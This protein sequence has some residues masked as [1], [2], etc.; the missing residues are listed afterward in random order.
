MASSLARVSPV[1][2]SDKAPRFCR[3]WSTVRGPL[4]TELTTGL[5]SSQARATAAGGAPSSSH[6]AS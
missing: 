5:Y 6:E 2:V 3:N 1:N 4:I